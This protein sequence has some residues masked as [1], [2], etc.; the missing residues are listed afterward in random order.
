LKSVLFLCTGNSARSI[1]AEAYLNHAARGRFRAHSAGSHPAGQVNP[2]A[3]EL[4]RKSALPTTRARS[5]SWDEFA[6]PG[7]PKMDFVFTVCDSAAAEVCP[8]WPGH[9]VTAHWG[10]PD[11]A[12]VGGTDEAKR[13][14]FKD[15]F[16]A[17]SRRIDLFLALPVEKLENLAL[18]KKLDEIGGR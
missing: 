6:A 4:L 15:A 5:K 18:K 7:A 1:L 3:L 16:T 14:A 9:P 10:V 17:L 2:F 12:A 11:P 8:V 13:R